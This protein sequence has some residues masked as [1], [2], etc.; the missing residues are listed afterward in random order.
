MVFFN[1]LIFYYTQILSKNKTNKTKM[2]PKPVNKPKKKRAKKWTSNAMQKL[3]RQTE[4]H[5]KRVTGSIQTE[6][7][8][9]NNV[10]SAIDMAK[11]AMEAAKKVTENAESHAKKNGKD[12]KEIRELI[13]TSNR[14]YKKVRESI[15]RQELVLKSRKGELDRLKDAVKTFTSN[16]LTNMNA[17][18][19]QIKENQVRGA[20]SSPQT[21]SSNELFA[22]WML[23]K[24]QL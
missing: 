11:E 22:N 20:A 1:F 7:D 21:E 17:A 24:I 15:A 23:E 18:N 14:I 4:T 9:N 10:T 16:T 19:K 12:T 6:T 13:K 8:K 3:A 5:S 2:D